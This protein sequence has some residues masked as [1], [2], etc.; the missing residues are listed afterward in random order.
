MLI[1]T[2]LLAATSKSESTFSRKMAE[3]TRIKSKNILINSDFNN[4]LYSWK[5]DKNVRLIVTN[6][7]KN[8][9]I[10]GN[11]IS[12][13]RIYQFI[14]VTSGKT[15]RLTFT[16]S[17]P[18]NGA[19]ALYRDMKTG[20]EKYIL[21]DGVNKSKKYNWD[22]KPLRSGEIALFLSTRAKG[23]FYFSGLSFIDINVDLF[24]KCRAIS[25]ISLFF[26][27]ISITILLYKI[28]NVLLNI[29]FALIV[30]SMQILPITK[31][32]KDTKSKS[33]NRNLAKY[34]SFFNGDKI[35]TNYCTDFNNWIND[36]FWG[37]NLIITSYNDL[38]YKVNH[39][40]ENENA[41]QG[42]NGWLFLKMKYILFT[43]INNIDRN[44]LNQITK[45][46][47]KCANLGVKAYF[48]SI[49]EKNYIYSEY[50]LN[51]N[52]DNEELSKILSKSNNSN[53]FSFDN[54]L[55][56]GK[57]K[58]YVFF[59]DDH[60]WTQYGAYIC[61][62]YLLET[63]KKDFTE[64]ELLTN[65]DF[66]IN[67][68]TGTYS[69]E[70]DN[71]KFTIIKRAGSIQGALNIRDKYDYT[72]KYK[73]FESKKDPVIFAEFP[74]K[75]PFY[76]IYKNKNI[77]NKLKIMIVG[78]SNIGFL[79][80]FVN[81]S[82]CESLFLQINDPRNNWDFHWNGD[83]YFKVLSDY[84]PD[85]VLFIT[86]SSNLQSWIHILKGIQ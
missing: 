47:E 63:F 12:Q 38:N 82:F 69:N 61:F 55:L 52:D 86:R 59:K 17:G 11:N 64:L 68:I 74:K 24:H 7:I 8:V 5:F 41:F 73:T 43:P 10:E 75:K 67:E 51:T 53:F 31:I 45:L 70:I 6:G 78:D 32:D 58:D 14:N 1:A 25:I 20:K 36:H 85:I 29:I 9:C 30:L 48:A 27:F 16:L 21:C 18:R 46:K 33:E 77:N 37:R 50:T 19:F 15:Y 84:K 4:D 3:L 13:T 26:F 76:S 79:V 34:K 81:A 54:V 35:N 40:I 66:N 23:T 57:N 65:E 83:K 62:N 39:R 71:K 22:I 42:K 72:D 2:I 60:H 49:P 44:I 80:P 56:E 28:L